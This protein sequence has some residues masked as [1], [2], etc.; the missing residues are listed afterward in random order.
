MVF[1]VADDASI[2][3]ERHL[4]ATDDPCV[5]RPICSRDVRTGASGTSVYTSRAPSTWE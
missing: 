4:A 2:G 5:H 3:A 1:D